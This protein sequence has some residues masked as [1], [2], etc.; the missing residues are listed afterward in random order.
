MKKLGLI[1]AF[2]MLVALLTSCEPYTTEGKV[3]GKVF[4]PAHSEH[5]VIP[6]GAVIIP[7]TNRIIDKWYIEILFTDK[8][9][10]KKTFYWG[11]TKES[12]DIYQI[13]DKTPVNVDNPLESNVSWIWIIIGLGLIGV[14]VYMIFQVKRDDKYEEEGWSNKKVKLTI[15]GIPIIRRKQ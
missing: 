13:G 1:I 9:N 2:V 4:E 7:I 6:V 8:N 12:Y 5:S 11:V 15:F 3:I 14:I 10:E